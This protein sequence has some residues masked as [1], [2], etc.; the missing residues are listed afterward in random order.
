MGFRL[1]LVCLSAGLL[2]AAVPPFALGWLAW[3]ALVPLLVAVQGGS[4]GDRAQSPWCGAAHG[5]IFGVLSVAAM[6]F[7]LWTLP[8]F[9]WTDAVVLG[10]YLAVFP[11][12]WCALLAW[13][14]QRRLPAVVAGAS[15][16]TLL[17][18]LRAHAGFLSL[19]WE[20]LSHSQ[21]GNLLL[22]QCASVGGAPLLAFVVCAGN[23]A[24]ADAW[25]TRDPRRLTWP[26]VAVLALHAFGLVR[27][28]Q[29]PARAPL[30][31]GIV[32]PGPESAPPAS[33]LQLQLQLEHLR[34]LTRKAAEA[35]PALIV[36]PE[37]A[38][39]GAAFDMALRDE[40]A[41]LAREAGAPI[42][43]GSAD[44]GKYGEDA[45]LSA[46][47][48][49]FK[50]QAFLVRPDGAWQGPYT[51]N[52]LVP[53][54][55]TVPLAGRVT[56]PRWLVARLR[57][58]IAGEAPGLFH[59]PDGRLAGVLICWENL[60]GDLSDRLAREGASVL[61]QLTNDSDF[62]GDAEP[63]QH[64]AASVLRA[65]ESGRPV[66]VASAGGPSLVIDS[67]GHVLEALKPGATWG[68]V[69]L[70]TELGSTVYSRCGLL[71]L[72]VVSIVTVAA[73]VREIRRR[74][75]P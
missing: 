52:R 5:A 45:G 38:I 59:L 67:R 27:L 64:N 73:G 16:W 22:L 50:N 58:G 55:E 56:W 42:L 63:L 29:T 71:W 40:M 4:P 60:F 10:A 53:F 7:F 65:V 69:S 70:N 2:A 54:A 47:E 68:T 48:M 49:P 35:R 20:P 31:L 19:P 39:H 12:A 30:A 41:A 25:R 11:A 32:Q 21:N 13:L 23:V 75:R 62:R 33:Q 37:S 44:F 46:E 15:G 66:V 3:V 24:M 8:A 61:V 1:G 43:F 36:W 9:Q 6:H 72:W 26:A 17:H 57:H 74:K 14:Q 28:R 34:G 51:K 18:V